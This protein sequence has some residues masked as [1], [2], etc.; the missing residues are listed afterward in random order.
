MIDVKKSQGALK[1]S[2]EPQ[3]LCIRNEIKLIT[4]SDRVHNL[5]KSVITNHMEGLLIDPESLLP[6]KDTKGW[7]AAQHGVIAREFFKWLGNTTEDDLGRLAVHLINDKPHRLLG[8][9]KVTMKTV[10]SVLLDCYSAKDW[11]ERTKRKH[12]V[13]KYLNLEKPSLGL[14]SSGGNYRK[15]KWK[16]FKD[17]Y[18]ITAA[19]KQVLITELGELFFSCVKKPSTKNMK[20]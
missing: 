15:D 18:S 16:A 7:T 9:P 8:Y 13:K 14:F 6:M 1:Q 19:T 2:G 11:L 17:E 10:K 4:A 12:G 3:Q 5:W 20:C